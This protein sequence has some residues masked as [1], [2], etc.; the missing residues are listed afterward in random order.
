MQTNRTISPWLSSFLTSKKLP[1][2]IIEIPD[3]SPMKDTY[4]REFNDSLKKENLKKQTSSSP[5]TQSS[6]DSENSSDG[7]FI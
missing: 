4:L 3:F 6:I 1:T 7:I 5:S 2:N